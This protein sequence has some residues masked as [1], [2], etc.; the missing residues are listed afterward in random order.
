MVEKNTPRFIN[1]HKFIDYLK[2]EDIVISRMDNGKKK[3]LNL[4]ADELIEDYANFLTTQDCYNF[5]YSHVNRTIGSSMATDI[6]DDA[7]IFPLKILTEDIMELLDDYNF[8]RVLQL[9][10]KSKDYV[11]D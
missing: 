11:D 10:Y 1:T 6:S 5:V 7:C 9:Y 4:S 8:A 3:V 2:K